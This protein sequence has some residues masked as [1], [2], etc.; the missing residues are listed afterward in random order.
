MKIIKHPEIRDREVF[1]CNCDS[2]GFADFL[3]TTKRLGQVAYG[4]DGNRLPEDRKLFP[5][6]VT[7][8]ELEQA[9]VTFEE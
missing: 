3:W 9:G 4:R 5:V 8:R 6:F 1:V 2:E 7:R